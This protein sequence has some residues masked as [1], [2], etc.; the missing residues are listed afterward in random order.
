MLFSPENALED[1]RRKV[2]EHWNIP[3]KQYY[4]K[5]D[6]IH[7]DILTTKWTQNT[8][9]RVEIRGLRGGTKPEEGRIKVHLKVDADPKIYAF[10]MKEEVTVEE[11]SDLVRDVF[12]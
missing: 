8:T 3:R 6:G 9:V 12:G 1:F 4:L 2:K 11:V 10:T 5:I 7:E